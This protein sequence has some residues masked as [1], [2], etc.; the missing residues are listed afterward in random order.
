MNGE[1]SRV[2]NPAWMHD[3]TQTQR[4]E[5]DGMRALL[6]AA[7]LGRVAPHSQMSGTLVWTDG[8]AV[9]DVIRLINASGHQIGKYGADSIAVRSTSWGYLFVTR[10]LTLEAAMAVYLRN[11][12]PER[13][14][15]W[16]GAEP[17][18]DDWKSEPVHAVDL[19][20]VDPTPSG[21]REALAG[22]LIRDYLP[23]LRPNTD[24]YAAVEHAVK[25]GFG[26]REEL[27]RQVDEHLTVNLL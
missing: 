15:N 14:E 5:L 18:D 25:Q 16:F 26:S 23:H 6:T 27:L 2:E 24:L 19:T 11:L 21:D 20:G 10:Q 22:R 17:S 13:V 4:Q 1:D 12:G 7:G 8:P 9:S 3:S